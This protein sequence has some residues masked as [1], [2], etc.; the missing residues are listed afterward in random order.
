MQNF[1][2]RGAGAVPPQLE[3]RVKSDD[4]RVRSIDLY[5]K[6][7]FVIDRDTSR[8]VVC[9]ERLHNIYIFRYVPQCRSTR[10]YPTRPPLYGKCYFLDAVIYGTPAGRCQ[11]PTWGSPEHG[12]RTP[13]AAVLPP[14]GC[15]P[16]RYNIYWPQVAHAGW[17]YRLA[18]SPPVSLGAC[19]QVGLSPDHLGAHPP[20][21]TDERRGD[22]SR[23]RSGGGGPG[24]G[25]AQRVVH[26]HGAEKVHH[27]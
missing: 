1:R 18:R 16:V 11:M 19:A 24:G 12:P 10:A 2:S 21:S 26:R 17:P 22:E 9:N 6:V 13:L 4:R 3:V 20:P 25:A 23:A 5:S 27:S 8:H 7:R 14:P 15:Q